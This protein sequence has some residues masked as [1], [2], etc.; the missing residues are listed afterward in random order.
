MFE[1]VLTLWELTDAAR[2]LWGKINSSKLAL[3]KWEGRG[4]WV[5]S[6]A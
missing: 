3:K 2:G 1:D 5:D 4:R 6:G